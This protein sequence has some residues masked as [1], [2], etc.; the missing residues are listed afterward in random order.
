MRKIIIIAEAGVNHNGRYDLAIN[1]CNIAKD[2]GADIVKFQTWK[3]E[4]IVTKNSLLAEYQK[5]NF[6]N[7]KTQFEMLKELE[8]SYSDFGKIKNHCDKIGI[9][10]LSTPDDEESLDFL[11]SICM[12]RIKIG[13][14]EIGNIPY[15]RK[16]G[17]LNK[18]VIL[19]TG[20]STLGEIERSL[21]VLIESGMERENIIVLHCNT[22]YPTPYKD[23]N[24]NAMITLKNAFKVKVGYSDHTLGIE[25]PIAAV[26]MGATVIEKHFTIDKNMSGP[27]HKASLDPNE[28]SNMISSIR[29]VEVAFGDG[30]KKPTFSEI[31]NKAI[32][33]KSIVAKRNIRK[34]D[35]FCV[36]NI[37]VKRCDSNKGISPQLWDDVIG[38][39]AIKNFNEDELIEI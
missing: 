3:T 11:N 37:T 22:E 7:F 16:I 38:K 6:S 36:K 39:T 28:L 33:R 10:F 5:S 24:L 30:I 31:K 1:L 26:A 21:D 32:V 12:K 19:S 18:E 14:G 35:I 34:N 13:S 23:V 15:L 25:I 17:K 9:E 2:A 29:K 27:D 4:N 8:L 20:I